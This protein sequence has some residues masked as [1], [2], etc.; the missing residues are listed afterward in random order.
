MKNRPPFIALIG[1]CGWCALAAILAGPCAAAPPSVN[2]EFTGT[3][4]SHYGDCMLV[5]RLTNHSN[6]TITYA[7]YSDRP[8]FKRSTGRPWGWHTGKATAVCGVGLEERRLLPKQS[9]TFTLHILEHHSWRIGVPYF[10]AD[11]GRESDVAWSPALPVWT[12]QWLESK[13]AD[14]AR[15]VQTKMIPPAS[16]G[17]EFTF[18]WTNISQQ[19]L[20]Y[21]GYAH[22]APYE[23]GPLFLQQ[24]RRG[25]TWK[26]DGRAWGGIGLAWRKVL[27][28]Q[29]VK[30]T[31]PN[32]DGKRAQRIGMR[33][34]LSP[35][36]RTFADACRPVW[37]PAFRRRE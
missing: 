10:T 3:E 20:Y 19:P 36:P 18:E 26:D 35:E 12:D 4:W 1:W 16:P 17:G 30:L 34:F 32:P 22:N 28:G 15:Y 9:K 24:E 23:K 25:A 7:G 6:R 21:A 11:T 5:M 14:P 8:L 29:S 13:G 27:P 2:L 37:W 31:R 33:I